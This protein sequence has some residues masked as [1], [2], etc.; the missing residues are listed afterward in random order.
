MELAS[1]N[2]AQMDEV[3]DGIGQE[4]AKLTGAEWGV[5][6]SWLCCRI[7]TCNGSSCSWR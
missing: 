4:L 2:F 6:I 1:K 5:G 7:K 3:A